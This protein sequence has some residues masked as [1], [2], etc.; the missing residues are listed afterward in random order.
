MSQ[1]GPTLLR[2]NLIFLLGIALI[3]TKLS[4]KTA[5]T[6]GAG[7]LDYES[8]ARHTCQCRAALQISQHSLDTIKEQLSG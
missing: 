3:A 1:I 8:V 6:A 7:A 4:Q 2:F 5:K